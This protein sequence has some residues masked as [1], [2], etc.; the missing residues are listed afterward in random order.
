MSAALGAAGAAGVC[1]ETVA[2]KASSSAAMAGR[3]F[4][5]PTVV[6]EAL[7]KLPPASSTVPLAAEIRGE[8]RLSKCF[9]RPDDC[10]G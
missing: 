1:A 3:E 6:T 9:D 8:Y 7:P 5:M 4:F 10:A 2:T